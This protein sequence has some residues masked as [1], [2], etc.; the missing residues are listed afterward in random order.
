MSKQQPSISACKEI[1]YKAS[2]P[3]HD[4]TWLPLW[5]NTLD[6]MVSIQW[7]KMWDTLHLV[8]EHCTK[9]SVSVHQLQVLLGKPL[10]IA[11]CCLLASLFVNKMMATIWEYPETVNITISSEFH[12]DFQWLC[13]YAAYIN[14][15]SMMEEDMRHP[16]HIYVDACTTNCGML[17][18]AEAYHSIFPQQVLKEGRSIC[19]LEALNGAN[20]IKFWVAPTV[21]GHRSFYTVKLS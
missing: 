18:Q 1:L 21:A 16:I 17:C 3:S 9:S 19:E 8:V 2:A 4:M 12:K 7:K 5:F 14:G 10:H 6:M 11:Q 15:V 13:Q 20:A